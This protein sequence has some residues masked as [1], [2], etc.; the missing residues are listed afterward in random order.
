MNQTG[1]RMVLCALLGVT[2]MADRKR[3]KRLKKSMQE[4]K[5][6]PA[7]KYTIEIKVD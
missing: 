2:E 3:R 1:I 4:N 6:V 5:N 7:R